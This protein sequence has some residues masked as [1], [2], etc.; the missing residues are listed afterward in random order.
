[1][2]SLENKTDRNV[3]KYMTSTKHILNFVDKTFENDINSKN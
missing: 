2:K 1:M 3:I